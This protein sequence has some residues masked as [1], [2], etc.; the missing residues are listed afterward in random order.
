MS[1]RAASRRSSTEPLDVGEPDLDEGP[2]PLL[3]PSLP[4]DLER[5]LVALPRL[6]GID[7]LL[8]PVIASNE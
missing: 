8:Q 1:R 5:L 6:G 4:R 3:K 2:D 7:P